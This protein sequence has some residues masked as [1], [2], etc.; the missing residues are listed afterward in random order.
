M[1]PFASSPP[2]VSIPARVISP[3]GGDDYAAA[4]AALNACA[5][6]GKELIVNGMC[7]LSQGLALTT[8]WSKGLTIRGATAGSGFQVLNSAADA[9]KILS[10]RGGGEG[11]LVVQDLKLKGRSSANRQTGGCAIEIAGDLNGAWKYKL[12]NLLCLY[13]Y[14]GIVI[15]G[16]DQLGASIGSILDCDVHGFV[17][18]GIWM[19]GCTE[20][21][22]NNIF[23]DAYL[24]GGFGGVTP[25]SIGFLIE[26]RDALN[27]MHYDCVG[28]D[29][30]MKIKPNGTTLNINGGMWF[31][32]A[33]CDTGNKG[34]VIDASG[35]NLD[36]LEFHSC[37]AGY[38]LSTGVEVIGSAMRGFRWIGGIIQANVGGGIKLYGG[39][40]HLIADT[41]IAGNTGVGLE[42]AAGVGDTTVHGNSLS[43][44]IGYGVKFGN[45][46]HGIKFNGGHSGLNIVGNDIRNNSVGAVTGDY[47]GNNRLHDNLGLNPKGSLTAPA[48]PASATPYTNNFGH[49]CTVYVAGGSVSAIATGGVT[50][51]MTS[52]AIRVPAGQT[53]TLT[54]TVA[55]T[56][57]WFGD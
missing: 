53:I 22:V 38:N 20:T 32:N 57:T 11:G 1:P 31:W 6:D 43:D 14:D 51:G 25:G 48:V 24:H 16:G 30:G 4:Q 2:A 28:A 34:F 40:D 27:V 8:G 21:R 12:D 52:G 5:A 41:I 45:Q 47:S 10:L 55:P 33:M 29:V 9:I 46:T 37:W 36:N 17:R 56:W 42:I 19:K 23:V 49:D 44:R 15:S 18:Y 7:L 26:S 50:T 39:D 13:N 35:E 3:S 54:Y